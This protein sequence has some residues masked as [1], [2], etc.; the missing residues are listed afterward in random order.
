MK[1]T[2][3]CSALLAMM[4]SSGWAEENPVPAVEQT[5]V[6]APSSVVAPA[7]QS[8]PVTTQPQAP[9]AAETNLT[10]NCSYRLPLETKTID[11]TLVKTWAEKAAVQSFTFTPAQ[12]DGQISGLQPC[13]TE[14]GWSSFNSALQKSGNMDAIKSQNLSVTSKIDDMSQLVELKDSQWKVTI[15]MQVVYQ[16]DKEKVTQSLNVDLMIGRKTSGDLGIM[17]IIAT[18]RT[19][20]PAQ[21]SMLNQQPASLIN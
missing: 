10:I 1:K 14:Q 12:L 5:P 19:A 18:P 21:T 2:L 16:N 20:A 13:F 7:P 3:V 9:V 4:S 11:T 8:N 6:T 15:P 17:Q